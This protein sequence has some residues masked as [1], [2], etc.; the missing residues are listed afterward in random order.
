[1]EEIEQMP[2]PSSEIGNCVKWVDL[3]INTQ[4]FQ[5]SGLMYSIPQSNIFFFFFQT[6]MTL[7]AFSLD[8]SA[9]NA[10]QDP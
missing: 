3:T 7:T 9:V 10:W 6:A 4:I 1:M 8:T 5:Q 2:R